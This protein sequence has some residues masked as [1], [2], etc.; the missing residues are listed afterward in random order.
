MYL[1]LNTIKGTLLFEGNAKEALDKATEANGGTLQVK[2]NDVAWEL[3]EGDL[4]KD[5]LRKMI[6]AQ[7][8]SSS[9]TRGR[10]GAS[11]SR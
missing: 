10:G 9:K 8:E 7:Q 3:L 5:E 6:Q 2:D 11:T 4:E 1:S